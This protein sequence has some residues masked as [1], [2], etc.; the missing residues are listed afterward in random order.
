MLRWLL[1]L[2]LV[3]ASCLPFSGPTP[4]AGEG[5]L[6]IEVVAGPVCP[7]VQDPPEPDCEA[8][9]VAEAP[10]FVSPGDG[11]DIIVA[12][13]TTDVAGL[14]TISLPPG[15][16]LL[17]A[18]DVEGLMGRPSTVIISVAAGETTRVTLAYDTGI[19]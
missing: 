6:E 9:P 5:R 4:D 2:P 8:R 17:A 12:E 3:L 19:R 10:L 18:G 11:R 1:V 16:Y 7:V 14:A 15:D 13:A